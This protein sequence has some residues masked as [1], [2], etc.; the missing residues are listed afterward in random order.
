MS[1]SQPTTTLNI[2]L[3]LPDHSEELYETEQYIEKLKQTIEKHKNQKKLTTND[4]TSLHDDI[5][6]ALYYVGSLS[7]P[8]FEVEEKIENEFFKEYSHA[9]ELAKKLWQDYYNGIHRP[10]NILKNRLFRLYDDIDN[11]YV[12]LNKKQPPQ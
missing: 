8:A 11:L 10:Y 4:Y 5:T 1:Q 2:D 7:M 12:N 9:P 6:R 3:N